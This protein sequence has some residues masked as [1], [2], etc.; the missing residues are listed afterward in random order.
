MPA[1]AGEFLHRMIEA[2]GLDGLSGWSY[3]TGLDEAGSIERG[4]LHLDG[5]PRGLLSLFDAQGLSGADLESVDSDSPVVVAFQ[6]SLA[7]LFSSLTTSLSDPKA[8]PEARR[9]MGSLNRQIREL[10]QSLGFGLRE[11]VLASVGDTWRVFAQPGPRA[12]FEGWTLSL[13]LKEPDRFAE[14]HASLLEGLKQNLV[15]M[16]NNAPVITSA[17]VA[18][19]ELQSVALPGLPTTPSWCVHGDEL[20]VSVSPESARQYITTPPPEKSVTQ[21]EPLRPFLKQDAGTIKLVHLDMREVTKTVLPLIHQQMAGMFQHL[22]PAE[23]PLAPPVE[24]MAKHLGPTVFAVQRTPEGIDLTRRGTLPSSRLGESAAS[25]V[26]SA[27]PSIRSARSAA[28][29]A[30]SNNNKKQIA[31][32]MHNFHS[33]R[34]AFPAGYNADEQGQPLLSWRVH[35]LPY[36]EQASLYEKFHLDE[37]WDSPHNKKLIESMPNVYLSPNSTAEAG[38]TTYLGVGGADGVFVRP[39]PDG[40]LG[41]RMRE[42]TD[43]VSKTVLTVETVDEA[44]VIWTK[45]GDFAPGKKDPWKNLRRGQLGGVT[46]G[47]ADG[48]VRQIPKDTP[49]NSVRAVFTKSGGEAV[50]PF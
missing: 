7:D 39:Q 34:G 27:L 29:E 38:K 30:S 49:D 16:G 22:D 17:R 8:P 6:L 4:H 11:D 20:V 12:L 43:G 28:L 1:D 44:A 25:L 45:P 40:L 47:Y 33:A 48:S 21:L 24:V 26:A 18:E 10:E 23:A 31:L 15:E 35:V 9:S 36:L 32:A 46:V 5:I 42:I 2:L 50:E 41:T 14:I 3:T 19:T 37:P 13:E